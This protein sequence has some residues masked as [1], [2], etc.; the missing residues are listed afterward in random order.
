MC[1]TAKGG[2]VDFSGGA[3]LPDLRSP[4]SDI[5]AGGGIWSRTL[6]TQ[7]RSQSSCLKLGVMIVKVI[8]GVYPGLFVKRKQIRT[9]ATPPPVPPQLVAEILRLPVADNP[10]PRGVRIEDPRF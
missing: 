8:E 10:E 1:S 6:A 7:S 5:P 3:E 2:I 4:I 9:G